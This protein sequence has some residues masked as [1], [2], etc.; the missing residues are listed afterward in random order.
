[1]NI[2]NYLRYVFRAC[3][4]LLV[5]ILLYLLV[6]FIFSMISTNPKVQ[7]CDSTTN[8]FITSNGVHLDIL[9]PREFFEGDEWDGLAIPNGI[10]Y[11]AVGWGDKGFYLDTPTWS[12]LKASTALKAL[13]WRSETAMHLT[14]YYRPQSTWKRLELCPDQEIALQDYIHGSFQKTQSGQLIQIPEAGY[15]KLD[16]F[17]EAKGNYSILRTC[18]NWA[19]QAVQAAQVKTAVWSPFDWGV[20]R[21]L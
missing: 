10:Q 20:L 12:D 21:H 15:T 19:N 18:N 9:V 8:Y 3:L 13:F 6:A 1:M 11:V 17:F 2:R 14:Y 16:V 5:L 7:A 4:F